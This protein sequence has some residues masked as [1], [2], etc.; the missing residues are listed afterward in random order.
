MLHYH[1]IY[2]TDNTL[3]I[4]DMLLNLCFKSIPE[5]RHNSGFLIFFF[6]RIPDMIVINVGI[7]CMSLVHTSLKLNWLTESS[8]ILSIELCF[9]EQIS[10]ISLRII[11]T[12][13]NIT[14]SDVRDDV[15]MEE[16]NAI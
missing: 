3:C 7:F 11:L 9:T 15:A 14:L 6:V 5:I 2:R 16:V 12:T 8:E 10:F 1:I 4:R 13:S